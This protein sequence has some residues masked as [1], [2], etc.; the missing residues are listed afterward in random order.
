MRK[1]IPLLLFTLIFVSSYGQELSLDS[2]QAMARKNHPLLRQAGIIDQISELRQQ[3]IRTLNLPQF[4][5]SARASWQSEVTQLALKLPGFAGPEPLSKDQYK[6]Y[7][8]I[9]QK[10]YDG[11]VAKKRQEL[12]EADRLISKQQ[13]ETD[14]YKIKETV[15]LLYFNVLILQEN[16]QIIELKKSTLDERIKIVGSAVNNGIALPNELDQLKAE[17]L[18]TEQQETELKATSQTTVSLLEIVTGLKI[19]EQNHF[20]M[21]VGSGIQ[22]Y[23]LNRPEIVLFGLQKSKIDKN[24]EV[25]TQSRKPFVYAF[26]QAGYGRPGLNMLDNNFADYYMIGAGMVWNIWDWH[27][28]TREKSTLKLQKELIDTNIDNFNRSV[29][30]SLNQEEKNSQKL[31]TLISTDEQLVAIKEQISKRS[32]VAL[33]NG[34]ITSADYIRDLN[35]AL[36]SKANLETH[37]VQL[38]QVSVNYQ[39]IKGK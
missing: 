6:A 34:T 3:N 31:K 4:D 37:K 11:G 12:E 26:G 2:C 25:L 38:I 16:L 21:P 10:L 36:Q 7:V 20:S 8:D 15:N 14:L 30:M 9:K 27:K 33:E 23:D 35:A 39:T 17:K 18:M 13:N 28:T 5:L 32:A 22:N 29:R 1:L 19:T 24:A